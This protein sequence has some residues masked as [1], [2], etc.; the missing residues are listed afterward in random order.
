[1]TDGDWN[2]SVTNLNNSYH[3]SNMFLAI[4]FA[5]FSTY[6]LSPCKTAC[7][8]MYAC[9]LAVADEI[10]HT[11]IHLHMYSIF[12]FIAHISAMRKKS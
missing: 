2:D 4:I 1:M 12:Y 11:F 3:F 6:Q 8:C 7:V 10:S 5:P 9:M